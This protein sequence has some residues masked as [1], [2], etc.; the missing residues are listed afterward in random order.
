MRILFINQYYPPDPA[1]TGQ[2]LS[3]L[4]E[5]LVRLGHEVRVI[6]SYGS[7]EG[8]RDAAWKREAVHV[9]SG[10]GKGRL[11]VRRVA[12]FGFGRSSGTGRLTDYL[13][14]YIS[15][16]L[17]SLFGPRPDVV[18]CLTTPPYIGFIGVAM[19]RLRGSRFVQWVMDLYPD[20]MVAHGMISPHGLVARILRLLTNFVLGNADSIWA[21]GPYMKKRIQS[22]TQSGLHE[23]ITVV[24]LWAAA[25]AE[26]AETESNRND[27]VPLREE[28]GGD[29][30]FLAMYSGNMGLGHE[31]KTLLAAAETMLGKNDTRLIFVG[32]G[33]RTSEIRQEA[34][35]RALANVDFKPYAP[36][37]RLFESLSAGD[38]HIV[39][40]LPSWQG[41]I[42]PSKLAGIFAVA[43]PALFIGGESNEIA[44]WIIEADAG[45]VINSG[46][47][48]GLVKTLET[49]RNDPALRK[50]LGRNARE[51]YERN[52]SSTVNLSRLVKA[53]EQLVDEIT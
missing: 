1:A 29:S 24:P 6:C 11:T 25:E 8:K 3:D 14:F 19:R 51:F 40:L 28:Y 21:L 33:P 32:G 12:A 37:E 31:L 36:R 2:F 52:L 22:S 13:S 43:R 30:S 10:G 27:L 39:S 35:K 26:P 44:R 34:R 50:R 16:L 47:V 4:A 53:V 5:E 49:L 42:V 23:R 48:N 46:D 9:S 17:H 41:I 18:I 15:A 7:Y 38:V 20:V 45:Y